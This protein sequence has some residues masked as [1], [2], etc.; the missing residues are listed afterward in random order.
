MPHP[1]TTAG[2]R[3]ACGDPRAHAAPGSDMYVRHSKW[4]TARADPTR[5]ATPVYRTLARPY[6]AICVSRSRCTCTRAD[7]PQAYGFRWTAK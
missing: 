3:P 7:S 6:R 2:T 4:A 1:G 5:Y